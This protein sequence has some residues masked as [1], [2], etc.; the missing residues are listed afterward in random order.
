[1]PASPGLT[2]TWGA[3]EW[4]RTLLEALAVEAVLLRAGARRIDTTGREIH[5][6]RQLLDPA[7]DW[8]EEL[9]ELPSDEGEADTL[10]L[11]MK[12]LGNVV[13]LSTESI[14]DSSIETLNGVGRAM[15]R[16]CATKL[17]ARAFSTS[18]ADERAPAGL[19]EA[20]LRV[21]GTRTRAVRIETLV[22]AVGSIAG[23]G[24]V[25]NAIILS[26]T[27]LT[28]LRLEALTGGFILT[29]DPQAPGVERIAGATLYP[30]PALRANEVLV[31]DMNYVVVGVRRDGRVDFSPDA[32]FS[33][34][35]VLA[36]ITMRCDY[37]WSDVKAGYV[38][39]PE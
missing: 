29:A 13:S 38:L 27:D 1:M 33:Q 8:V 23:Y 36:R 16:G 25:P 17:D 9:R 7:S 37:G 39:Q 34:D 35:A 30:T 10:D 26:S 11:L 2:T 31:A 15:V 3:E 20:E 5:V 22:R 14:Q 12:K 18:R 21:P 19:F 4:G 32:G 28:A 24:G 6:P